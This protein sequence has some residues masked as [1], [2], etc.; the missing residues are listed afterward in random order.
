MRS[1]S[2]GRRPPAGLREGRADIVTSQRAIAAA[3][4]ADGI[5]IGGEAAG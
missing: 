4:R 2:S 3:A 5:A 1:S